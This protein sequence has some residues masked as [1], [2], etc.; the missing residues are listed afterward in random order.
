MPTPFDKLRLN[1]LSGRI[2]KP[3]PF[4][5]FDI[6]AEP[7]Y[8]G[9][10]LNTKFLGANVYDGQRHI[11]AK[12]ESQLVDILCG[13]EFEGYWLYAHNGSGYDFLFVMRELIRRKINFTGYKTGGRIFLDVE[14]RTLLDSQAILRGSLDAIA[15]DLQLV[16]KKMSVPDDF[17]VN[18]RKYWR[19]I[20]QDYLRA[21]C[22]ALYE[23]ISVIR[24]TMATLGCALKA[25]LASTAL[26]LFRRRFLEQPIYPQPWHCD[27]E[28]AARAAYAGGRVEVFKSKMGAGGSWDIN[29]CYPRAMLETVPVHYS[30]FFK[31]SAIP[32]FGVVEC[33]INI[34]HDEY[35]PPIPLKAKSGKLLFPTGKWKC[36][37]TSLE[38]STLKT[39][40]GNSAVTVQSSHAFTGQKLFAGFVNALYETRN[41]AKE[42]GNAS[43]SYCCKIAMNSLYGKL[44]TNRAREEILI[45][46]LYAGWPFDDP[47]AL[48]GLKHLENQGLK[49]H[50]KE[51]SS[52][53]HIYGAPT[54]LEHAPYIFPATGAF[55][56]AHSR[57]VQL[58]P[59]LDSAG[60]ELIYCDTDNVKRECKKPSALYHDKTGDALGALK[61]EGHIARGEFV[62]PKC[63][64]YERQKGTYEKESERYEGAAKG[65]SR[66]SFETVR[67]YLRGDVVRGPRMLGLLEVLKREK[68]VL[69][70]SEFQEKQMTVRDSKRSPEGRA[71]RIDE[72]QTMGQI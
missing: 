48:R 69:P 57:I 37:L 51:Y 16:N 17:Y 52:K 3:K 21:D 54:F 10:P 63:Y 65:L 40:Y 24:E 55:I 66:K 2:P 12:T 29:S 71:W 68:R 20:G 9:E 32:D 5:V 38:A 28:M 50:V 22:A 39:R 43:L 56:T 61:L 13:D 27:S 1:P 23:A 41:R 44:A 6:E 15:K 46:D 4:A 7:N 62:A 45:G 30:G 14:N 11:Q 59:L 19:S 60:H 42:E 67:A 35:V 72:L 58:Q 26:D 31:G 47:K 64:W 34:P 8:K 49:A 25:T 33:E 70:K 36:W 53:Y 18:I